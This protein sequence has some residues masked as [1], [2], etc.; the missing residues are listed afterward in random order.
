VSAEANIKRCVNSQSSPTLMTTGCTMPTR[1]QQAKKAIR[2]FWV[3]GTAGAFLSGLSRTIPV[4]LATISRTPDWPYTFELIL[5][6]IY[7]L[8]FLSYFAIASFSTE[9]ETADR[10]TKWDI[11]YDL[12]HSMLAIVAVYYLGFVTRGK[13]E[14]IA[15]SFGYANSAI[16]FLSGMSWF[17]FKSWQKPCS[18]ISVLRLLGGDFFGIGIRFGAV[19]GKF[20]ASQGSRNPTM[21]VCPAVGTNLGSWILRKDALD[22]GQYRS[23]RGRAV[24]HHGQALQIGF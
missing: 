19:R 12:M 10:S 24:F 20:P 22:K 11:A 16:L 2:R 15:V 8:W 7:M 17:M 18:R 5:R 6:Y 14:N 21:D 3:A 4:D 13:P 1:L 23:L 9:Q